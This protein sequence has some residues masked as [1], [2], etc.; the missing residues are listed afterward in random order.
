MR[1]SRLQG[2][3]TREEIVRVILRQSEIR[4][5]DGS[6]RVRGCSWLFL[7]IEVGLFALKA[8]KSH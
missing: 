1:H 5:I 6:H 3:R 2:R 7:F 4:T 8:R